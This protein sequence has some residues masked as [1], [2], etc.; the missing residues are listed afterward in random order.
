MRSQLSA[1][2]ISILFNPVLFFFLMPYIIVYRQTTNVSSALKWLLFSSIFLVIAGV[3]LLVGRLRGVFSDQDLSVKEE[4]E[5]FY[6]IALILAFSYLLISMMYKG[7]FFHLSIVS[8]GIFMGML[9]FTFVNIY[10]K[11]SIHMAVSCA[12]ILSIAIFYG[13]NTL[14]VLFWVLPL[15]AWS[16]LKLKKHTPKELLTGSILGAGITLL[17]FLIAKQIL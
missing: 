10:L 7:L 5:E 14:I 9:I 8:L 12:F 4:R 2:L 13:I 15:V 6:I 11:A 1:K 17:T 3:L 16:R